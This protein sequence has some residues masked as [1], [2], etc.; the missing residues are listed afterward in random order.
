MNTV[1]IKKLKPNAIIPEYKTKGSAGADLHAL[2]EEGQ[3]TLKPFEI[4]L[5]PTGLAIELAEGLE[6]QIRP[7]SSLGLKGI[8]IPN[9][10]GTIDCDYRGEISIVLQNLS[11][12]DFTLNNGDRIAQIIISSV[13]QVHF[14]EVK[15]LS[16]TIRGVGGF[17]STGV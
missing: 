16:D 2:I 8:I 11:G 14:A 15:E 3:I 13:M 9:S 1:L 10:P 12:K 7:R 4:K 6:A 17:G 5:I